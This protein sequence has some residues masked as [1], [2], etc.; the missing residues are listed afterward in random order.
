[1]KTQTPL[2]ALMLI[3]TVLAT[4][5]AAGP[6]LYLNAFQGGK[7]LAYDADTGALAGQLP[8][9]DGAGSA[10]A[11]PSADGKTLYVVDGDAKHRLRVV[12]AA[13]LKVV[14]DAP[15]VDRRLNLGEGEGPH[16]T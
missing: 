13:G 7:I 12:A 10:Y 8:V 16:L 15:F 1:M 6:R 14:K 5:A 4:P 11:L 2:V 9:E 3:G